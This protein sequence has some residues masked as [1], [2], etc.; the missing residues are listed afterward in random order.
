MIIGISG[1]RYSGK[2]TLAKIFQELQLCDYNFS[3]L[4]DVKT[5]LEPI[6]R[7][8]SNISPFTRIQYQREKIDDLIQYYKDFLIKIDRNYLIKKIEQ[9][10]ENLDVESFIIIRDISYEFE[11]EWLKKHSGILINVKKSD[12]SLKTEFKNKLASL[13]DYF[14][15]W[16]VSD[17]FFYL[18]E[19]VNV[20][21]RDLLDKLKNHAECQNI[22]HFK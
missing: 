16:P 5:D 9:K 21:L 13:S 14:V 8:K 4:D 19:I 6:I 20:Q 11:V 12:E 17:N 18:Q 2:F 15:N 7:D 1:E 22:E 10:I 3:F